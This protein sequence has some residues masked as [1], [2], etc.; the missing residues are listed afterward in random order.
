M[1]H[2]EQVQHTVALATT[3][4]QN[5]PTPS[6]EVPALLR[7]IFDAVGGLAE[8]AAGAAPLVEKPTSAAIRKSIT[9]DALISFIDGKS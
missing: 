2:D 4:M 6:A 7:T 1:T 8:P 5:H 9:P 3:H